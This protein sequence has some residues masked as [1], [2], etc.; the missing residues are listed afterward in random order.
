MTVSVRV[1]LSSDYPAQARVLMVR[2]DNDVMRTTAPVHA[3]FIAPDNKI[4]NTI[5]IPHRRTCT[6]DT[7]VD[8]IDHNVCLVA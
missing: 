4:A 6:Y 1:I 2:P 5:R 7:E 3:G 8:L